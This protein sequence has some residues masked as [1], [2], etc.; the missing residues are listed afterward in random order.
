MKL[1]FLFLSTL[2]L[3]IMLIINISHAMRLYD[4][5]GAFLS[6]TLVFARQWSTVIHY[7]IINIQNSMILWVTLYSL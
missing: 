5:L 2:F 4:H 1:S 3:V 6:A 7:N